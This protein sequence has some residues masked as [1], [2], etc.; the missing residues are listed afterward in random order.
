MPKIS[1][2]GGLLPL[3]NEVSVRHRPSFGTQN[4]G[5]RRE[6]RPPQADFFGI[7]GPQRDDFR[8]QIARRRRKFLVF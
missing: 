4:D 1:A 8:R 6:N 7:W 3:Y 5:F 2:C